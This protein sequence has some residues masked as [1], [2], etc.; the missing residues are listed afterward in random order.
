[1]TTIAKL[2]VITLAVITLLVGCA[3]PHTGHS[4]CEYRVV[5]GTVPRL[6]EQIAELARDG[7]KLVTL[8]PTDRAPGELQRAVAT[9]ERCQ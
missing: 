3:T 4:P 6:N 9:L 7:W 8:T 5:E 2:S 1:M